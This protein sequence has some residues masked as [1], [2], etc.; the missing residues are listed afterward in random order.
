VIPALPVAF[1]LLGLITGCFSGI[2]GVGGGI[3]M[4]P[5]LVYLFGFSQHLA[6]GTTLA[7]FVIPV[8]ILGA[9]TYYSHGN[10]NVPAALMIAAGF[11]GGSYIGSRLANDLPDATLRKIFAVVLLIIGVKMLLDK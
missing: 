4:I 8:G 1:I 7:L 3:I 5:A 9:W 2:M 11:V 6:Q 10:L